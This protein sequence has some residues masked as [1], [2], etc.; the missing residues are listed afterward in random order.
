M[1]AYLLEE[2]KKAVAHDGT[3]PL[4]ICG[5]GVSTQ[6]T[7][8]KAPSWARL[9]E[10]GI[11]RVADLDT[12]ADAWAND[13]ESRLK[14]GAASTWIEVA[15]EITDRLGGPHNAEF[16]TWIAEEVGTLAAAEDDALISAIS[17]LGCPIATTN[18]DDVLA[19]AINLPPI[20]WSDPVGTHEFLFGKRTG[21]PSPARALANTR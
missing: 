17:A 14:T 19:K 7:K 4:V 11:Q 13:S 6:A 10:L 18:Y 2:L 21:N 16:A 9:I 15:D 12:N 1:T 5:A 8:G 20:L 3:K